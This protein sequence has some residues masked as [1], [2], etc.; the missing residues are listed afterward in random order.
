MTGKD[1]DGSWAVFLKMEDFPE[2]S[3]NSVFRP[4]N[5]LLKGRYKTKIQSYNMTSQRE[6]TVLAEAR[7]KSTSVSSSAG[8]MGALV[9]NVLFNFIFRNLFSDGLLLKFS[10]IIKLLNRMRFINVQYGMAL[11][12]FMK[13]VGDISSISTAQDKDRIDLYSEKKSGKLYT[14]GVELEIWNAMS[15][16]LVLYWIFF[17]VK[18]CVDRYVV[19]LAE[20]KVEGN[21][22]IYSIFDLINKF[23]FMFFSMTLMDIPFYGARNIVQANI[24]KADLRLFINFVIA[25]F[26]FLIL[27]IDICRIINYLIDLRYNH[28]LE[29]FHQNI[30]VPKLSEEAKL[31]EA[32]KKKLNAK[33]ESYY[34]IDHEKTI[35]AIRRNFHILGFL[36]G[37]LQKLDNRIN[38][39]TF[40]AS[41][42]LFIF[43]FA[44]LQVILVAMQ[45][46]QMTS[47][48]CCLAVELA[49]ITL[50]IKMLFL[51][52]E[53]WT[54]VRTCNKIIQSI[55][56]SFFLISCFYLSYIDAH[57]L[58][59]V[60]VPLV[61]QVW[62]I[63]LVIGTVL[64]EY[65][66]ALIGSTLAI[67]NIIRSIKISAETKVVTGF[68]YVKYK[69]QSVFRDKECF[70][71]EEY[72]KD[73]VTKDV[74]TA[75][76]FGEKTADR[77][78][79]F[80]RPR[81]PWADRINLK[82]EDSNA[83]LPTKLNL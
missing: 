22:Y 27:G 56:V 48:C 67:Q 31:D 64:V 54:L 15:Y 21:V 71:S 32:K 12:K 52:P 63:L 59:G 45:S 80:N 34:T 24:M 23:H 30:Y 77:I 53:F 1:E 62:T 79:I 42:F 69:Q 57:T 11:E 83:D 49:S 58:R 38:T 16:V 8:F 4:N 68:T 36:I 28:Q 19:K 61:V 29:Q 39:F 25:S 33:I 10:M 20:K 50:N 43:R 70:K 44:F 74:F 51:M 37:D 75:T 55:G 17:F 18:L 7:G 73:V 47:V 66:F 76:Q 3:Y 26:S 2:G 5:P 72:T 13:V 35:E 60:P 6:Q 14:Y 9:M 46:L 82:G 41:V 78:K 40:K 65:I 81:R